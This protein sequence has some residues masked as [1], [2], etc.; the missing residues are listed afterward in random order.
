MKKG[1]DVNA[2]QK[3]EEKKDLIK[4]KD[5][6]Y[7]EFYPDGVNVK[8]KGDIDENGKRMGRW[9]HFSLTGKE[10]NSSEYLHGEL[11]GVSVVR[12]PS[13]NIHYVGEYV[14]GKKIGKWVFRNQDGSIKYERD[15]GQVED[16]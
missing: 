3:P 13:G 2:D 6:K 1:T 16:K 12:H 15:Y 11:H 7:T 9:V 4:L 14:H 5:K 10:L 8:F